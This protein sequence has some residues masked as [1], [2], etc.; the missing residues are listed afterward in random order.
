M[1]EGVR[2]LKGFWSAD[3]DYLSRGIPA[4]EKIAAKDHSNYY[5]WMNLSQ[6][7]EAL[8]GPLLRRTGGTEHN[9]HGQRYV[10]RI[11]PV[12]E[13]RTGREEKDLSCP[14]RNGGLALL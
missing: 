2:C 5:A 14:M 9:L 12:V 10:E 4:L 3:T 6:S 1:G 11:H 8:A 7:T 13:E